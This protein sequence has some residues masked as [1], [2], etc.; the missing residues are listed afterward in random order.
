[1]TPEQ[2]QQIVQS[3]SGIR[4]KPRSENDG[5]LV[6]LA[7]GGR[8]ISLVDQEGN[9][10]AQG[11]NHGASNGYGSTVRFGKPGGAY[12]DVNLRVGN[13]TYDIPNERINYGGRFGGG[14]TP[15]FNPV[16]KPV[17]TTQEQK[18]RTNPLSSIPF[19]GNLFG[20]MDATQKF[21]KFYE[22]SEGREFTGNGVADLRDVAAHTKKLGLN[23]A[24]TAMAPKSLV[25]NQ[26]FTKDSKSY[27]YVDKESPLSKQFGV[28]GGV[29]MNRYG[30]MLGAHNNITTVKAGE[31]RGGK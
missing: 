13:Q 5:N 4:W 7:Q 26:A 28:S 29:G 22:N 21:N 1:M 10:V 18:T 9:L 3:V 25:N 6:V 14:I 16:R 20:G 31:N 23:D 24:G 27:V 17:Q 8:P 19:V 2:R 11:R 12:G 30:R 15:I